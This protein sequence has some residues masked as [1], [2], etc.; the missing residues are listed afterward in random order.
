MSEQLGGIRTTHAKSWNGRE[1]GE[2][3]KQGG[4]DPVAAG[5]SREAGVWR[6]AEAM[7]STLQGTF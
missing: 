4:R 1:W 3:E 7:V 6:P 2:L 5:A